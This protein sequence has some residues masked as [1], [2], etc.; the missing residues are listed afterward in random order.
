MIFS[1][2]KIQEKCREQNIPLY[3]AFID[4]TKAF[5]L[6]SREGHF[7]HLMK[8]GRPPTLLEVVTPFNSNL[9]ARAS[10]NGA[11]S[12]SIPINGGVKQSYV[13][14]PNPFGIFFCLLL[15]LANR[16]LTE[17]VLLC[18]RSDGKLFN[19]SQLRAKTCACTMFISE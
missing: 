11:L 10:F 15:H 1:I 19:S 4:L 14:V 12:D 5:D 18:T 13:L 8:V 7:Q 3:I 16:D 2:R 17:D 6:V 9:K